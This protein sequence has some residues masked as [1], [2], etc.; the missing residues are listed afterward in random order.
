MT[1]VQSPTQLA[2]GKYQYQV[3]FGV[4][5]G[6]SGYVVQHISYT[7]SFTDAKGNVV[8]PKGWPTD[9]DFYEAWK[10]TNGT[11]ARGGVDLFQTPAPPSGLKGSMVISGRVTFLPNYTLNPNDGWSTTAVPY[12]G[13]LPSTTQTPTNWQTQG[14]QTHVLVVRVDT[15][16]S[17]STS[18]A[19]GK[20]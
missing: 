12:S 6:Q 19:K 18:S 4:P 13:G 8:Q 2:D 9:V 7:N 14:T 17:P 11:V 3:Q 16:Q 10:V 20:P 1:V 5:A 15:T